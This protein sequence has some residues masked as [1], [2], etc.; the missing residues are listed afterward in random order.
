VVDESDCRK[1]LWNWRERQRQE[2]Y[3]GFDTLVSRSY[4]MRSDGW[5]GV[6]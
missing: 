6:S 2:V 4:L 1:V 3:G 5:K